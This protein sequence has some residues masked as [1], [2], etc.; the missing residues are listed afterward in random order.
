MLLYDIKGRQKNV[1]ISRYQVD[2]NNKRASEAQFRTKKFLQEFWLGDFV[3]EEFIIP[4][5]RLRIDLLNFTKKIAVEV[6]GQ[7]HENFNKFF[8]KN[9][10]GFIKSIKRDFQKIK[11][12]ESNGITLVEIYD[13]ETLE[14]NKDAIE[15]KFSIIL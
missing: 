15:K 8:H 5:S 13:Y 14:L 6:S 11:W 4:G 7:Q 10:I 2:W 9:R 12:I 1:N 3:C